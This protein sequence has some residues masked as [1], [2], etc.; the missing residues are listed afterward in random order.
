MPIAST[1]IVLRLTTPLGSAGNT[2]VGTAST[3]LGKYVST[4]VLTSGQNTLFDNISKTENE[5]MTP[6]YRCVAVLNNHA[7]LTL[8]NAVAFIVTDLLYESIMSIAVDNI[9]PVAKGTSAAQGAVIANDTTAPTG[10]STFV[11]SADGVALG[12]L[13]PGQVRLIWIRRTPQ[14]GVPHDDEGCAIKVVGETS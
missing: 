3:S 7:T 5:N 4:T 10:I 6:D 13:G 1:D 11:P 12:N 8:T 9:G 2:T 14:N